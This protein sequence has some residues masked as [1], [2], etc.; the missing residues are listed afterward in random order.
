VYIQIFVVDFL[1]G[2]LHDR[3][4]AL[5][6]DM[7]RAGAEGRRSVNSLKKKSLI[8]LVEVAISLNFAILFSL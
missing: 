5:P 7:L 8:E 6:F 1:K 3:Q 4:P 2:M